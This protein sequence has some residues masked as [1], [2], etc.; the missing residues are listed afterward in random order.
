MYMAAMRNLEPSTKYSFRVGSILAEEFSD[1]RTF[2][3]PV[4]DTS[5]TTRV[6]MMADVDVKSASERIR[7]LAL[8]DADAAS[9]VFIPGDLS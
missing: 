3:S 8:A 4:S 2:I 7:D 5:P 9:L 1:V 6:L